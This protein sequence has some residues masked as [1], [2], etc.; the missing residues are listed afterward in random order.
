M[1]TS[2][3]DSIVAQAGQPSSIRAMWSM[4]SEY[5]RATRSRFL[6]S[7]R[8]ITMPR[9]FPDSLVL[10]VY[11]NLPALVSQPVATTCRSIGSV[12]SFSYYLP[13]FQPYLSLLAT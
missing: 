2:L 12:Y 3:L 9:D 7:L 5:Q 6:R 8:V 13:Q 10:R 4:V 11:F 1:G